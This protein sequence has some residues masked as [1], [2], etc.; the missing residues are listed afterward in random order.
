MIIDEI[1]TICVLLEVYS[2]IQNVK[3]EERKKV[4]Y[5][6][7]A[8]IEAD[9]S[10]PDISGILAGF[11]MQ[12][13]NGEYRVLKSFVKK[14]W[15]GDLASMILS[16]TIKTEEIV[17]DDYRID[18]LIYEKDKYAIVLENKI[19]DA[20]DQPNQ[21]ANYIDAMKSSEYGFNDEQIYVSFLPK[22][23]NHNPSINSWTSKENG[24]IY[25]DSFKDRY[26]LID[27]TDKILPW[28][29]SSKEVQGVS[30]DRYFEYSRFLF[31]DYLR[32]KLELDN[33][34]NMTQIEIE[35]RLKEH[36]YTNDPVADA[37]KL[38]QIINRLPKI[39]INEVVKQL[40]KLRKEKTLMAMQEW[41]DKMH[42][43]YQDYSIHDD[44]C[45]AHL[46]V[47]INV[48]YKDIPEFF[49]VF[50]WNFH[51]S[52][53][54]SVGIELTKEGSPYRK[55]IEAKVGDLVR[56]KKGFQKGHE[57]LYYKNVSYEQ[58]YP[59][60]QELVRELPSI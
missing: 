2:I 36:L 42:R 56:G 13:T 4:P 38:L 18:I 59:L 3:E 28:L 1:S 11:F 10:E 27:F 32:R 8:L 20:P 7:N 24:D 45:G 22:T 15:G 39:D 58:A 41:V 25:K 44:R 23:K 46:C 12:K 55:D 14:F 34:D 30:D 43:D 17:K 53:R 52:E 5:R 26:R 50:I 9:L 21:L 31:I 35:K 16:P 54:L 48:P 49:K 60:L 29:E 47:G 6:F 37:D 33:I 19:W 51:K 57:W 40:S